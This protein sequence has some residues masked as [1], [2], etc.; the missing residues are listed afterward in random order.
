MMLRTRVIALVGVVVVLVV[1]ALWIAAALVQSETQERYRELAVSSKAILWKKIVSSELN[2]MEGEVFSVTRSRT[3]IEALT[4]G[5]YGPIAGAIKP[6]FNRLSASD[7]L[8]GLQVTDARARAVFSAPDSLASNLKLVR[9][10]LEQ[11]KIKRGLVRGVGGE[12][13][14]VVAFPLYA[15]PGAPVGAGVFIRDL[16]HAVADFKLNDSAEVFVLR[17]DGK[18]EYATDE[19]LLEQLGFTLPELGAS[20]LQRVAHNGRTYAVAVQPLRDSD[21]QALGHLVTVQDQ[22]ES[23]DRQQAIAVGA[24][25]AV[26]IVVALILLGLYWYLR[27]AFAPLGRATEVMREVADGNLALDIDAGGRDE[28]GQLMRAVSDMRSTLRETLGQVRRATSELGDASQKMA[29]VTERTQSAM[30]RQQSETDEVAAAMNEMAATV[31]EVSRNAAAAATAAGEADSE[32]H[33]GRQVVVENMQAIESL[34]AEV[35]KAANVIE[36][37]EGETVEIGSVLEVIRGI[38]EQTNLLALNAAIEAARAGEQGRGFAVVADEVRTLASR[39]QQSTQEIHDMIERLQSGARDA[40]AVMGAGR[41]QAQTSVEQAAS[42]GASLEAITNRVATIN[43][44]N[45]QIATAA[46][47]QTSVAEEINRK[48]VS[49]AHVSDET[50]EGAHQTAVAS[51]ELAQLA[52]NLEQIVVRFKL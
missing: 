34:A 18:R 17:G 40:V 50:S 49:I 1:A 38:A 37:L 15:R 48:I 4:N 45:A 36:K 31:L 47:E 23:Y 41:A 11:G 42:A 30:R 52:R 27:R 22:S 21:E 7:V 20:D 28:V 8:S 19:T 44:M 26:A 43:E 51:E 33:N 3:V 6:A 13:M 2:A 29:G 32:A 16:G 14:A 39:T 24:Y 46:E 12:L 25:T 5:E 9:D 35:V 10:A